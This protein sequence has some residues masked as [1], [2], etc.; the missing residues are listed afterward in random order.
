MDY[1]EDTHL[2]AHPLFG[3]EVLIPMIMEKAF[4]DHNTICYLI[5]KEMQNNFLNLRA[6]RIYP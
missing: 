1:T 6:I 4:F 2:P 5:L 3:K